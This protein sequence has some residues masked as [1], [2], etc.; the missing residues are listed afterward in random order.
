MAK[1][2]FKVVAKK[3]WDFLWHSDSIWSWLVNIILAFVIIKFLVYPGLGLALGT[4]HPIVAVVSESMEHQGNMD[5]WWLEQGPWYEK[6]GITREIFEQFPYQNGFD[7]GDIMILYGKKP[8]KIYV[9][10]ILIFNARQPNP[11]I[12]RIVKKWSDSGQYHFQTKG[13]NNKNSIINYIDTR[14]QPTIRDNPGAI[15]IL[16]ETD[17]SE[18]D[19]IGVGILRVPY[20][21]WIKIIFTDYLVKPIAQ[22]MGVK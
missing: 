7:K 12:H 14:G 4:T 20:L 15:E 5:Q 18:N 19:I 1:N 21:G 13:D 16:D 8:S 17:I 3:V 11:I 22:L 2:Q 6:Q 10:N 9:G